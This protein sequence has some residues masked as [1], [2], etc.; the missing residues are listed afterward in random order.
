M[1]ANGGGDVLPEALR[2][3]SLGADVIEVGPGPGLTTDVLRTLSARLTAVE[4]DPRWR[5]ALAERLAGSNVEGGPGDATCLGL[6][7][8]RFTGAT[9]FHMLHHVPTTDAQDRVFAE[10]ARVLRLGG[11]LV[12]ADSVEDEGLR[13][14]HVDDI[15]N[16]IDP[17]T[18][19]RRLSHVVSPRSRFASTI[20]DGSVRHVSTAERRVPDRSSPSGRTAAGRGEESDE[21]HG[22]ACSQGRRPPGHSGRRG[23]VGADRA[24]PGRL[25]IPVVV[26]E[27][28]VAR[29]PR[30]GGPA[31]VLLGA[32]AAAPHR[33]GTLLESERIWSRGRTAPPIG[34][35]TCRSR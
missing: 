16:P 2:G 10:L 27:P 15:Y 28:V 5:P 26:L 22:T 21:H 35:C 18:F 31:V 1:A 7:T 6:P 19:E 8:G 23:R 9:S 11:A 20:S 32:P 14:F 33:S 17:A 25:R 4:F 13:A 12:A 29:H 34:S 30:P 24:R 3:V